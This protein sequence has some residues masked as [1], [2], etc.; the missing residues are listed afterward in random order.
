MIELRERTVETVR[1]Y[2]EKSNTMEI[3]RV[4]PQKAQSVEEAIADFE[5]TQLPNAASYGRT[6]YV[7]GRYVGDIW[8]YCIDRNE[9][10]NAMIS[11]CIFDSGYWNRGIATEALCLFTEEIVSRFHFQTIGAFTYSSNI[12]SIRVLEKNKFLLMEKFAEDGVLSEYYQKE[13]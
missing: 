9:E 2:F 10:P 13:L 6:I 5:R 7:D 11:Y 1:I 12:A 8:C 4:L 3:K